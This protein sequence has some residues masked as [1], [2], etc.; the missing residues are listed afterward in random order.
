MWNGVFRSK[1]SLLL[2]VLSLSLLVAVPVS[3][4]E[5]PLVSK[6]PKNGQALAASVFAGTPTVDPFQVITGYAG[7]VYTQSRG[8]AIEATDDAIVLKR[9]GIYQIHLEGNLFFD[10][11]DDVD[12]EAAGIWAILINGEVWTQCA[13]LSF[14]NSTDLPAAVPFDRVAKCLQNLTV[15]VHK[16]GNEMA[17]GRN[18]EV[19]AALILNDYPLGEATLMI[20][21]IEV[22]R[23][24]Q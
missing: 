2:V 16:D 4:S 11:A 13:T 10:G 12:P 15:E 19:Q 14:G 9:D 5:R 23:V 22:I 3:A 21:R 18:S 6:G 20:A 8:G 1:R 24:G 17:V 7:N